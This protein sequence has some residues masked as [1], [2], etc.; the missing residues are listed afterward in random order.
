M[1]YLITLLTLLAACF[2]SAQI[3][4]DYRSYQSPVK[5]QVH[6]GTCTAFAIV[7]ALETE[8][9]F[10]ND[11]SEQYLY[12][13]VKSRY[14]NSIKDYTEGARLSN[15]INA[16]NLDGT[17]REDQMPYNPDAPVWQK[18]SSNLDKMKE[19]I[20]GAQLYD[21]LKMQD[22]TYKLQPDMYILRTGKE[23][24]D[25][26]W[27]KKQLDAGVK[28]ITVTYKMNSIMWSR[29][30]GSRQEKI[31]PSEIFRVKDGDSI[32]D[33]K[34]A[35]LLYEDLPGKLLSGSLEPVI[36]DTTIEP[37]EGHAVSIV[38][39]DENGFLIKNS[40]GVEWGDAGYGWL[41][42]DYHRLFCGEVMALL[43]GK[44]NVAPWVK[45]T[46]WKPEQL[47]L[48][49]LPSHNYK[50]KGMQLSLVFHSDG[51]SDRL[52]SIEYEVYNCNMQL[53]EKTTGKTRGIFDGRDNGYNT[54]ILLNNKNPFPPSCELT[55]KANITA[56]GGKKFTN[57]YYHVMP[58]NKEYAPVVLSVPD[59]K[60]KYKL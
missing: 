59:K 30:S 17:L 41:S 14:Y 51:A 3:R 39:Y 16:L 1:R 56:A 47:Y 46:A 50:G 20:G 34:V 42:F 54:Y 29:N 37:D 57:T 5:D 10:P 45:E 27:I 38:G 12:A 48:K 58:Y 15:Y 25:I 6:R 4:I 26:E 60:R 13:V 18:T 2:V 23:A 33:Y 49:S 19:D 8:P 44:V 22:F 52:T 21:I 24:Q 7:A 43:I 32:Y 35:S 11:L 40:W 28:C 53:L 31:D 9:G 55:I 36:K